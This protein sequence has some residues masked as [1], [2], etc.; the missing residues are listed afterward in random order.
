MEKRRPVDS[1]GWKQPKS[2]QYV[3]HFPSTSLW[4]YALSNCLGMKLFL[5]LRSFYSLRGRGLPFHHIH[6]INELEVRLL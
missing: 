4:E 6:E 3:Y 2:D 1:D 5:F